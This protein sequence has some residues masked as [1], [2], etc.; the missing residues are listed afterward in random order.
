MTKNDMIDLLVGN[1]REDKSEMK[2]L[3]KVDLK[4]LLEEYNDGADLFPNGRD[5]DAEGENGP[6]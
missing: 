5:Y 6:Y 2:K 3:K 4:E 1:Y